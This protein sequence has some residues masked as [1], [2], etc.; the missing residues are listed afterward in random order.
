MRFKKVIAAVVL[1]LLVLVA[2]ASVALAFR[3]EPGPASRS[4]SSTPYAQC[5]G[6]GLQLGA[7]PMQAGDGNLWS[8]GGPED[9]LVAVTARTLDMDQQ[10]LVAELRSGKT[11]AQV[12][13]EQNVALDTIITAFMAPRVEYLQARLADG[14]L[15]QTQM[16]TLVAQ[17]RAHLETVLQ[18]P[19]AQGGP[20]QC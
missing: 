16:D 18:Q 20:G 1:S 7:G 11:L 13:Q 10:A 12:A 6:T 2:S 3:G 5:D 8:L 15:T 17:M 19:W 14:S 4:A 9:S